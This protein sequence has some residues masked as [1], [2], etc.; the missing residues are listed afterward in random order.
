MMP[1]ACLALR[2]CQ[3]TRAKNGTRLVCGVDDSDDDAGRL[4][5][6]AGV[7]RDEGEERNSSRLKLVTG[8]YRRD[9]P[10]QGG[11]GDSRN[12]DGGDDTVD[13]AGAGVLWLQSAVVVLGAK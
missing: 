3:G 12:T 6:F 8:C 5:G 9:R 2:V 13:V 10:V 4:F 1:A 7:S 11:G